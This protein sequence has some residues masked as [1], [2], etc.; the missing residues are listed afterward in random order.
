MIRAVLGGTGLNG[1]PHAVHLP[2]RVGETI[3]VDRD[4]ALVDGQGVVLRGMEKSRL[5]NPSNGTGE[6]KCTREFRNEN[7]SAHLNHW[8]GIDVR[9][10]EG[11][12]DVARDR[13]GLGRR[14]ARRRRRIVVSL[15]ASLG[16]LLSSG[17]G[18]RGVQD[19]LAEGEKW[20]M[21]NGED[22]GISGKEMKLHGLKC[23]GKKS[24]PVCS[25]ARS[26]SR[27]VSRTGKDSRI[28][29][30]SSRI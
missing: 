21:R 10:A 3:C 29:T 17:R 4:K 13:A 15:G 5:S 12:R 9:V 24:S 8:G 30:A 18:R 7:D 16:P 27:H 1:G 19:D 26:T 23:P 2:S 25:P 6:A 20:E 11:R 14:A 28:G 22:G